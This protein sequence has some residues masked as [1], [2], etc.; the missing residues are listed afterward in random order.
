MDQS[1]GL[2]ICS[3]T[4]LCI[5]GARESIIHVLLDYPALKHLRRELR[6]KVRDVFNN[7]LTL[8]G[9]GGPRGNTTSRAKTVEAILEFLYEVTQDTCTYSDI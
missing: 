7:I 5:Y 4:V 9:V 1:A 8:L 2:V 3:Y 6:E